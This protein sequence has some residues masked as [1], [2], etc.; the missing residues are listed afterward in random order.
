MDLQAPDKV[1]FRL[2]SSLFNVFYQDLVDDTSKH[3][4]YNVSVVDQTLCS[5]MPM[6]F[7]YVIVLLLVYSI[8]VMK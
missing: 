4:G 2:L 3:I 6:I 8:Y 5:A 7:S 1:V